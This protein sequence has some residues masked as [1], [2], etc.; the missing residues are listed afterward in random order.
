MPPVSTLS[1][2]R[3]HSA[4]CEG[5]TSVQEEVKS[6]TRGPVAKSFTMNFGALFGAVR[7]QRVRPSNRYVADEAAREI[8]ERLIR[9]GV[10]QALS[11]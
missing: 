7:E 10:V 2:I 5:F 6:F 1:G 9:D 8:T 11:P 3:W 4:V